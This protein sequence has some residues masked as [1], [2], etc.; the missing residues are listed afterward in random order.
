MTVLS[1][2]SNLAIHGEQRPRGPLVRVLSMV[3]PE[4]PVPE[5]G[6]SS[7][8]GVR[9]GRTEALASRW[10]YTGCWAGWIPLK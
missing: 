10:W 6:V 7:T 9:P 8:Q 3:T 5:L 1:T 4:A 2:S